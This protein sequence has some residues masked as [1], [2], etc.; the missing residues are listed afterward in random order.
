MAELDLK[1]L[2]IERKPEPSRT[3]RSKPIL[4]RYVLPGGIALGFVA[5]L[6]WAARDQFL[7]ST[8]V[9][10]VPVVVTRAEVQIA[11]TPLFQAAGWVEP[12]PTAV[13]VPALS[14]GVVQELLVVEGQDVKSGDPVAKLIDVDAR[15]ALQQ[16][17]VELKLRQ[18]EVTSAEAERMA[19][20]QRLEKPVH[21]AAPLAEAESLLASKQTEKARLPFL[22]QSS[23][24]QLEYAKRNLE[25]KESAGGA[26]SVRALQQAKS[27]LQSA[28]ASLEE[29]RARGPSLQK[30]IDTLRERCN[31]LAA[32]RELLIDEKRLVA[33]TTAKIEAAQSRVAQAELAIQMAQLRLE[34]MTV[35]S[36]ID[37]RVLDLL[38]QPGARV[39]GLAQ[40]NTMDSSAVVSLYDPAMLQVRADVRLEDV[41]LVVAGQP[42]RIEI[43]SAKQSIDGVVLAA[44]SQANVQK[45]TLEVKVGITS[46]PDI[47]RPEM[48]ASAT[49]LAPEQA[50]KSEASKEQERLLVPRQLVEASGESQSV[51]VADA[52]G[53]AR[54]RIV[55][56]GNAG[57]EALVEVVEGLAPTDKLIAGGREGLSDGGRIDITSED[58]TIGASASGT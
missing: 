47:I 33:D 9:T 55:R 34:R 50:A 27:E 13:T 5:L 44:T 32:Q 20:Q 42:V 1:Q 40:G 16:A 22:V 17:E 10:V 23:E 39:A 58:T 43:A 2:T 35:R 41:P 12:R 6:A 36:P 30:E 4:S 8:P 46:P 37:G 26:V 54:R 57:T 53:I 56:L 38:A 45:N 14:E 29:L 3:R 15:L 48:L 11:G 19:A 21:L 31:A 18:T 51:W 52:G 24:A 49:F 7:T 28:G 25:G